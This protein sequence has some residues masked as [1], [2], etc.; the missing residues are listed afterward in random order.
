[1]AREKFE[2]SFSSDS[3]V[4]Y[5]L[6]I[7][8]NE[9]TNNTL[10]T[11]D[12]S[13]RGFDLTYQ[14][15]DEDRFTGLIPSE[16]VFDMLITSNA[17]QSLI[18]DIK[19]SV[20]GRWQIGVYR[21]DD[22]STGSGTYT[23]FWC[24]NLLNDISPEQDV[25]YP[26]EFSLTAVCGLS[27]LQDIKFNEGIGYA[28][29]SSFTC[30]QY[31]RNAFTL[32][33]NTDTFFSGSSPF[34][35]FMRTFVDWTTDTMTHQA[36]RD[37]LVYSRFNFMAF[38]ELGDDGV[39]EYATTF[40]L[41]DSICKTFGMRV[42]FSNGSWVFVQVNYYDN[43][44]TGNTHFFRTYN[45]G[46]DATGSPDSS[47]STS[48]V[49]QEG[50][51]YKRLGGADFDYLAVLKEVR[52]N[53]DRLQTFNLP[54]LSYIN[55][56]DTGTTFT[57][58]FNEIPLWNG[59]RYNN[60]TFSGTGFD[61]N[62]SKTDKYV[63]D[64]GN[65]VATTNS[66]LRFNRDFKI[67]GLDTFLPST[68]SQNNLQIKIQL[69]FK[70]V[71]ASDTKYAFIRNGTEAWHD[72][73]VDFANSYT[74]GPSGLTQLNAN[75]LNSNTT[76]N[77]NCETQTIP[78]D[79]NLFLEGYAAIYYN[80][81]TSATSIESAIQVVEGTTDSE[82]I[83]CY[84]PPV[85]SQNGGV[86]YLVDGELS[87]LEIYRATNSP[88]GTAI[89]T[90]VNYKVPDLLV[91]SSPNGMGRIEVYNFT[92]SAWESFNTT[93]KAFN[94]GS[95]T[96]IT[97][98]LVEEILKGQNL[99]A[100][101]FNGAIKITDKSLLPYYFGIVIDGSSFVP[102]QCTFNGASDTWSGEWYEINTNSTGQTISVGVDTGLE[103]VNEVGNVSL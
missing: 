102:Y 50:T 2:L 79:G 45:V 77:I 59:Y 100:R 78:F 61:I 71:G 48:A 101:T 17:Q 69:K 36:D 52:A 86:Q 80:N 16:L 31:F 83:L 55:N 84:S 63:A 90:G 41:L 23:L 85:Y 42:F 57:P 97:Q 33:I 22:D 67:Q 40:E 6:E 30:L 49:V 93:W 4:Y 1:M 103:V 64:L 27:N 11:P 53:Y 60:L 99:G 62:N 3:S 10:H 66:T 15:D 94:A 34:G 88:G 54:F 14:T 65:I 7:Y 29:P 8:D 18:N 35:K 43:W 9:A 24:G 21:S 89:S 46:N 82:N 19:A 26:R 20:Y 28:T 47:G 70:L 5:R 68:G 56:G 73:D 44:T 76:F 91:G 95:G 96:R 37:P 81:Y 72:I 13:S 38:V 51:N 75:N 87:N 98:L 39:K 58:N 74:F 25:A 12:L 32:Q 92:T